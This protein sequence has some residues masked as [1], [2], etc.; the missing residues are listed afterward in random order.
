VLCRTNG[1]A[2]NA[3]LMFQ[4]QGKTAHLVGGA[5]EIVRFARAC[6]ELQG[7]QRTTH[8]ELA[9]FN[10]WGEVQAYVA[11]DPGG[12][13]LRMLVNMVDKYGVQI[14]VDALDGCVGEAGADVVISTAHKAKGREWANVRLAADFEPGEGQVLAPPE[15]RLLYV[16]ATR[17][18]RNLDISGCV[19][20]REMVEGR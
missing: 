12:S 18:T 9:C 13:D 20:L 5:Q 6:G 8:P 2:V 10:D 11:D 17:A 3:V 7:G 16:A 1:M 15:L 4:A 14:V 19:P